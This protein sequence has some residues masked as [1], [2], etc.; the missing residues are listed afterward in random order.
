MKEVR[1]IKYTGKNLNDVFPLPCVISIKKYEDEP[2]LILDRHMMVGIVNVAMP[3]Q[4][5]I[6]YSN[7]EWEIVLSSSEGQ[8]Q[9]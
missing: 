6:E 1:R 3:G 4:E 8:V 5:L 7:G 9:S 2:Y